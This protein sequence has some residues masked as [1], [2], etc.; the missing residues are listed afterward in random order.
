MAGLSVR[1]NP[2]FLSYTHDT[3]W[4]LH[5]GETPCRTWCM[6]DFRP[7]QTS[8][9][10]FSESAFRKSH[11]AENGAWLIFCPTPPMYMDS[12]L[13]LDNFTQLLLWVVF[14]SWI[15]YEA[16]IGEQ[17]GLTSI[18]PFRSVTFPHMGI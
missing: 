12:G 4:T 15:F 18:H 5:F 11:H 16:F 3:F 9:G 7:C 13:I 6:A 17:F 2:T 1:K 14:T 8:L 10:T